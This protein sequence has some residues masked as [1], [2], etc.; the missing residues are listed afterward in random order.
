MYRKR[1]DKILDWID[2]GR[3]ISGE[4]GGYLRVCIEGCTGLR[5]IFQTG[6]MM[7]PLVGAVCNPTEIWQ[8]VDEMLVA[9][10]NEKGYFYGFE[11]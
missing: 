5:P 9:L 11:A 3:W 8:M 2:L 4:T 6:C 7:D 1:P 10:H